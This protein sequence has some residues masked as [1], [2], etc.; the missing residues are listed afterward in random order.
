M[1]VCR[2]TSKHQSCDSGA[3]QG[4]E[5]QSWKD[6]ALQ[7]I[8]AI[9][10]REARKP[11]MGKS[12]LRALV[13]F[14]FAQLSGATHAS[15][16]D[17]R[18]TEL[19]SFGGMTGFCISNPNVDECRAGIGDWKPKELERIKSQSIQCTDTC[20]LDTYGFVYSSDGS[21]VFPQVAT[22][23]FDAGAPSRG[24]EFRLFPVA[25]EILK[26]DGCSGCPL[27]KTSPQGVR[28][29]TTTSP[30]SLPLLGYGVFYL[31]REFRRLAI[32]RA[33]SGLGIEVM[34]DLG[35]SQERRSISPAAVR[36]YA[37]M[38]TALNYHLLK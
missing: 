16:L 19:K 22:K 17:D 13:L 20:P 30:I 31:P 12:F 27:I 25:I 26:Y 6:C 5:Q 14:L 38:L 18:F 10:N 1:T 32:A 35:Q 3:N 33:S 37:K 23:D 7:K 29:R 21:R 8:T 28:A 34:I 24:V 15:S 36:E 9:I 11:P 4:S 2:G